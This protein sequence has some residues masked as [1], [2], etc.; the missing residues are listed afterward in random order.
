MFEHG[1]V[2]NRV[3][4]AWPAVGY[5]HDVVREGHNRGDDIPRERF[6]VINDVSFQ[7]NSRALGSQKMGRSIG[8]REDND[9]AGG[10][11]PAHV[12]LVNNR[13][14]QVGEEV[15]FLGIGGLITIIDDVADDG[16]LGGIT[17]VSAAAHSAG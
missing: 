2:S 6:N 1:I 3:A 8:I 12:A 15:A 7:V 17:A 9:R 4:A 5:R 10:V 11:I 13:I 16:D 14:I